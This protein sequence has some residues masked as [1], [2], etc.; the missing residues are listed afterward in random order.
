MGFKKLKQ[1]NLALLAKQGWKL[2]IEN[3]SLLYR[4]PKGKYF[5]RCD[6][7]QATL[8]N[9]PSYTWRS[10]LAAQSLVHESMRRRIGNGNDIRIWGD[11]W[12][13]MASTHKAISPR[14]FLHSNTRV[15][16]LINFESASWNSVVI[17]AL[18]Y[19]H[20]TDVI[21]SLPLSSQVPQDELIWVVSPN[22]SFSVCRA[23]TLIVKCSSC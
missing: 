20:K 17:D 14:R 3:N 2:Q 21:K 10:I 13:P 5:P 6:F 19:P 16:E 7:V 1:F 22:G 15:G 11:K 4:V 9:N 8:S 12:L 23:Y 18:F